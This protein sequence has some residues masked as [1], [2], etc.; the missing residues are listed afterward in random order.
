MILNHLDYRVDGERI[1]GVGY[2]LLRDSSFCMYEA[3][4]ATALLDW[5]R[6]KHGDGVVAVEP[7]RYLRQCE[8]RVFDVIGRRVARQFEGRPQLA[9]YLYG[10]GHLLVASQIGIE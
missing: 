10:K 4:I 9:V 1:F 2:E 5:R 3:G 8:S 6:E 7:A